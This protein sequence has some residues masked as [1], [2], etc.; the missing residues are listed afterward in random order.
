MSDQTSTRPAS[1]SRSIAPWRRSCGRQQSRQKLRQAVILGLIRWI[2]FRQECIRSRTHCV[3]ETRCTCGLSAKRLL[4]QLQH[5]FRQQR[6]LMRVAH[7]ERHQF[8]FHGRPFRG[9]V[10]RTSIVL[11]LWVP[12]IHPHGGLNAH[13][14]LRRPGPVPA[15]L[16][17][18]GC[19]RQ[20]RPQRPG[21]NH[22]HRFAHPSVHFCADGSQQPGLL[23]PVAQ[24]VSSYVPAGFS[25]AARPTGCRGRLLFLPEQWRACRVLAA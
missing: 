23:A 8:L 7:R 25:H 22:G 15:C 13:R 5:G 10:G 3:C 16:S 19:A 18:L 11:R 4:D 12:A 20:R 17:R 14:A 1:G 9:L 6:Q 21:V 24:R 2:C